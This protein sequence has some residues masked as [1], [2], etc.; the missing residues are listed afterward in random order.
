MK[1]R[2]TQRGYYDLTMRKEGDVFELKPV[3]GLDGKGNPVLYSAEQQFS[4]KWM[5]SLDPVHATPSS[6]KKKMAKQEAPKASRSDSE[7]I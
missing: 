3:K 1:V 6:S 5:E 2:A 7:V 4:K